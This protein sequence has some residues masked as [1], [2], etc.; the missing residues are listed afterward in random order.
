[1]RFKTNM[2]ATG[3]VISGILL[4]IA[5]DSGSKA[6]AAQTFR[7]AA[8]DLKA[9]RR[10]DDLEATDVAGS[11]RVTGTARVREIRFLS[12]SWD[13]SGAVKAIR[14]QAFVAIP[15]DPGPVHSLPAVI[16]AHGLGSRADAGDAAELA[17]NLNVVALSI[18][19]PGSGDSE[20]EAPT[21]QD[22]GPI[23]R[24]ASDI[25]A[26]WLYQY[27]YAILRAVTYLQTLP[28]VDPYGIVVTGFSM[29]GLATFI[30]GGA[31]DRIA[32][33]VPVAAA[34]GLARAAEVDTWW[35]RLVLSANGLK[36]SDAGPRALFRKLDPLAF[37]ARLHGAVYMLVGAQDE[38]FPLDQVI[39]TYKA[40]RAR[41]KR[42]EVVV[43]YDHGWY[44]GAGCPA[45]CMPGAVTTAAAG[46]ESPALTLESCKGFKCPY[47]CPAGAEPPYCGPERSYNR[48]KDFQS[49]WTLLLR[50]LVAQF[51]A[52]PR[53]PFA[54]APQTPFIQRVRTQVVVRIMMIPPPRVVRLAV[55]DNS[56]YTFGQ[57]VL[58]RERDGAWHFRRHVAPDAILIAEAETADGVTSTS[59]P[60]LPRSYR[61]HARPFG[62]P[63]Q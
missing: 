41:A 63:P 44:F 11:A 48:H 37:A 56:G 36:P 7:A 53:R 38:F 32:G 4:L 22:P 35:R 2:A 20:G 26:N 40:V 42:L 55:S 34:G 10:T 62:L 18:S 54:P 29:G 16:S 59:V 23:F 61:P 43:D 15:S 25:R 9:A 28:E 52:H 8:F 31:D 14:I 1:L 51:A 47:V 6:V 12:N 30:V 46:G 50:A 24:G 58:D 17:Q 33:V 49:R 21:P 13:E 19:A 57:Y 3:R 27:A 39:R 45:A 60:L 5:I